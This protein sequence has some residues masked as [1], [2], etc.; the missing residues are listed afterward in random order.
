VTL[1]VICHFANSPFADE[2]EAMLAGVQD[3]VVLDAGTD[4][5]LAPADVLLTDEAGLDELSASAEADSDRSA[6]AIPLVVLVDNGDTGIAGALRRGARAA[7]PLHARADMIA[8]ALHAAA[9]GLVARPVRRDRSG[10]RRRTG[11]RAP[12]FLDDLLDDPV[13][14]SPLTPREREVL[15]LLADGLGNKAVA[16]RLGISAETVKAHVSAILAKLHST[17]RTEAVAIGAR[18]GLIVL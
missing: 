18:L 1:R 11:Q 17:T 3:I 2:V 12:D 10:A 8:A 14:T 13:D 7:L 15:R 5:A 4:P 9:A 16:R 6:G